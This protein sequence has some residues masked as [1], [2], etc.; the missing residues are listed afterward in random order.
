MKDEEQERELKGR[1]KMGKAAA[2]SGLD[3]AALAS[4]VQCLP[5]SCW[6]VALFVLL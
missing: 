6:L 5:R 4:F 2:A 1:G 3:A